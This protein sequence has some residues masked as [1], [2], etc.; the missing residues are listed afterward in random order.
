MSSKELIISFN[1]DILGYSIYNKIEEKINNV[2]NNL[3]NIFLNNKENFQDELNDIFILCN[4]EIKKICYSYNKKIRKKYDE[5]ILKLNDKNSNNLINK[6][7]KK[8]YNQLYID[9]DSIK[10]THNNINEELINSK[11]IINDLLTL[12]NGK[13]FFNKN[14][15]LNERASSL[16]VKNDNLFLNEK[17][18]EKLVNSIDLTLLYFLDNDFDNES[19][20]D[21]NKKTFNSMNDSELNDSQYDNKSNYHYFSK[22]ILINKEKAINSLRDINDKLNK[23]LNNLKNL[24]A[25]EKEEKES[26]IHNSK[27]LADNLK[28][29]LGNKEKKKDEKLERELINLKEIN[30]QFKVKIKY[31]KKEDYGKD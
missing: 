28:E 30:K 21:D 13:P 6:E 17:N 31:L 11:N 7:F 14:K 15:I 10:K 12:I 1:N 27:K 19:Y 18:A 16:L 26:V 9:L 2:K 4:K 20:K 29:L 3:L 23:D 8:I 25:H 5:L 24:Y 22:E